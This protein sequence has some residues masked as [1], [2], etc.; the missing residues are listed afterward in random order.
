MIDKIGDELAVAS[1]ADDLKHRALGGDNDYVTI[2]CDVA[3]RIVDFLSFNNDIE[4]FESVIKSG[5]GMS[6]WYTCKRCGKDVNPG[7]Q[8]CSQCGRKINWSKL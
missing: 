3:R 7:D 5:D 8:F 1:I 6:N 4:S 2:R